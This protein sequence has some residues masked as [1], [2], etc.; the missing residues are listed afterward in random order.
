[1]ESTFDQNSNSL[2]QSWHC[3]KELFSAATPS[4]AWQ[5]FQS[6]VDVVPLWALLLL[7]VLAT[8]LVF[9]G[10]ILISTLAAAALFVALYAT[11]KRA[12]ADAMK[13]P[14]Y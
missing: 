4:E 5:S 3:C 12:V 6:L 2:K 10:S 9:D 1:M 13:E 7:P 8:A 14:R 11:V